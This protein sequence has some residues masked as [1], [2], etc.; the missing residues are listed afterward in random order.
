TTKYISLKDAEIRVY[1]STG[2]QQHK[3]KQKEFQ[4]LGIGEGLVEDGQVVY[5]MYPP[6]KYPL[7]IEY[8]YDLRFSGTLQLM[9]FDIND[10]GQSVQEAYFTVHVPAEIGFRWRSRNFSIQPKM[11]T[12]GNTS[13]YKFE[14]KN[15][16]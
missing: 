4:M 2:K 6:D 3:Y 5:Y 16:P 10:P 12:A 13:I 1:D 14:V 7:T 11:E 8:E 9:P 15:L